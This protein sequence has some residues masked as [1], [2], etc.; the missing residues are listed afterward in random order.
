MLNINSL[1]PHRPYEFPVSRDWEDRDCKASQCKWNNKFSRK[2]KIPSIAVIGDD[3]RC[4]G[5]EL[6]VQPL[7]EGSRK[8][9]IE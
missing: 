1:M 4:K 5:F 9:R 3:G 7:D 8:I 6:N 2:C